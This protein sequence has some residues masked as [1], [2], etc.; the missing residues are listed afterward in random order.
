MMIGQLLRRSC[1][2]LAL[3]FAAL[4]P[5]H[6]QDACADPQFQ[7][8]MNACA[9]Q[10]FE[11]A[12]RN[13]DIAY[14][15]MIVVAKRQD[16]DIAEISPTMAGA[17][18]ALRR[19]QQSWIGYRDAHCEGMGMGARGGSMEPMLVWSCKKDLTATRTRELQDMLAEMGG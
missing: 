17:E 11:E 16:V 12:D 14:A 9:R 15:A 13:L 5:A 2:P 19:A 6:A 10:R 4:P 7:R 3:A 1:L 8:E 18:S